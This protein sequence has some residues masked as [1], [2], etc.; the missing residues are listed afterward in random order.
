M[1]K[2]PLCNTLSFSSA[3]CATLLL[4]SSCQKMNA[5]SYDPEQTHH[6]ATQDVL[7]SQTL[8]TLQSLQ[9]AN[10]YQTNKSVIDPNHP[11]I[12]KFW[13]SWCPLCLAT[14]QE[15]DDWAKN[16]PI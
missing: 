7:P 4:L 12:V 13:A 6:N 5:K 3:L 8:A 15:S 16:I 1:L 11:T 10:I 9:N 2:R 14:L